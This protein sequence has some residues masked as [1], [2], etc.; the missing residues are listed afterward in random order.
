MLSKNSLSMLLA[1]FLGVSSTAA[2]EAAREAEVARK[3]LYP[4]FAVPRV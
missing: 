1:L 4:G 2:N 3:T